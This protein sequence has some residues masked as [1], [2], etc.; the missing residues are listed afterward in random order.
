MLKRTGMLSKT[1]YRE[2]VRTM[3]LTISECSSLV[4]GNT[5]K[6]C[7]GAVSEGCWFDGSRGQY[8]G[9]EVISTAIEH[10][11]DYEA[12]GYSDADQYCGGVHSEGGGTEFYCDMWDAAENFMQQFAAPGFYFGTNEGWG[13][14]G[15]Y[16]VDGD[17]SEEDTDSE[18]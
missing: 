13:D 3:G 17:D 8:I 4:I 16:S 14:W 12:A 5:V 9:E 11:W 15:L 7:Y 1:G 10:G 18:E 6:P 2:G